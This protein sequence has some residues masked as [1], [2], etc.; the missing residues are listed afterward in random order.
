MVRNLENSAKRDLFRNCS[1]SL[2]GINPIGEND[3]FRF[4]RCDG[5]Y[6]RPY[7][8]FSEG[9]FSHITT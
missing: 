7:I 5:I 3:F 1:V 9:F 2:S 6:T 8:S 4:F